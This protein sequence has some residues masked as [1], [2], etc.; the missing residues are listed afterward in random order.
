MK[1]AGQGLE[2]HGPDPRTAGQEALEWPRLE[3]IKSFGMDTS[4][5]CRATARGGDR[6]VIL[7]HLTGDA[8]ASQS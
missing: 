1:A 7:A 4:G 6:P 2:G 5:V 8:P 3:M